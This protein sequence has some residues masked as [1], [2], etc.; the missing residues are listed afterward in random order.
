[1][2]LHVAFCWLRANV[3]ATESVQQAL[4]NT[5]EV[6]I[7]HHQ[8]AV[9]GLCGGGDVLDQRIECR[10]HSQPSAKRAE[11]ALGVPFQVGP[12]VDIA[13]VG[14]AQ[15]VGQRFGVAAEAHGVGA[16]FQNR[17]DAAAG[18]FA[19]CGDGDVDRGRVMG[20]VVVDLYATDFAEQFQPALDALEARQCLQ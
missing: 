4:V 6:A 2:R 1:M 8:H 15:A 18:A 7:T 10:V 16:R 19:Q 13:E 5:S 11:A 12:G 17:E 20:E 3:S 14:I 9:A